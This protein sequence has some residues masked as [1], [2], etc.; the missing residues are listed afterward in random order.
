MIDFSKFD[1][2]MKHAVIQ[3]KFSGCIQITDQKMLFLVV[4]MATRQDRI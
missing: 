1:E 4:H 2:A 3:N